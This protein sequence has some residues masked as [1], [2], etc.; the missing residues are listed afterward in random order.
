VALG[1]VVCAYGALAGLE[2]GLRERAHGL[3]ARAMR[4]YP[5]DEVEALSAFVQSG[6]HPLPA[7]NDAIWALAQLADPRALPALH[8]L[9]TGRSCEHERFVCQ[10]ELRKAIDRCSGL[11]QRPR[12]LQRLPFF[13]HPTQPEPRH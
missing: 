7:R 5:G 12:W 10:Y 4:E 9:E 3:G 11:N 2:W 6:R 13:P 8:G 1:L